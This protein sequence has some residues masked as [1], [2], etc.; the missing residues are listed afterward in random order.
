MVTVTKGTGPVTLYGHNYRRKQ[1]N[2]W[3]WLVVFLVGFITGCVLAAF[4]SGR[5]PW[6]T[7]IEGARE[8][9]DWFWPFR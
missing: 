2:W 4:K 3:L 9:N 1:M 8:F 7:W 5:W 6:T